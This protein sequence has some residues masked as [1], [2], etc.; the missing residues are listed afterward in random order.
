MSEQIF[1][2]YRR[3]DGDFTAKLICE[4][5]KNRGYT[6]FYDYDSLHDGYFN[7]KIM[8]AIE[9]CNDFVLVLPPNALDRCV[10]DDDWLRL[11]I[12]YALKCGINIIPVIL[13]E[14]SFPDVLPNDIANVKN[15]NGVHFFMPYFDA[16]IATIENR[17]FSSKTSSGTET[18]AT[19]DE[20]KASEGLEFIMHTGGDGYMVSKGTCTDKKPVIPKFYNGKP[21]LYI[22]NRAFAEDESLESIVIPDGI[23][24]IGEEAFQSCES[25][26]SIV[27]PDS[28]YG[29]GNNVFESC[30]SLASVV[31]PKSLVYIPIG[32]FYD[33][34][35]LTSVVIPNKV[36]GIGDFA[37]SS[38]ESLTS[39]SIPNSV[40]TIGDDAFSHC[41]SLTSIS[42]PNSV[43]EIGCDAFSSCSSL[44]SIV[45]PD[46]VK[47]LGYHTFAQCAALV[48]IDLPNGITEI[49]TEAFSGCESLVS[50][51]IPR[52]IESIECF[53]FEQCTSLIDV[54]YYGTA[55]EWNKIE[56]GAFWNPA[57]LSSVHCTDTDCPLVDKLAF[58]LNK[59]GDGYI[60]R[61]GIRSASHIVIPRF[62][63]GKPVTE[64]GEKAFKSCSSLSSVIIPNSVTSIGSY[65]FDDCSALTLLVLPDTVTS[66]GDYAFASCS[67][68]PLITIPNNTVTIGE[69]AFSY[70]SSLIIIVLPDSVTEIGAFAFDD[71]NKL[72]SVIYQGTVKQ[73]N[74]IY[75]D[76]Y[77]FPKHISSVLCADGV[78]KIQTDADDDEYDISDLSEEESDDD[79]DDDDIE[80]YNTSD[81]Q[82]H[83]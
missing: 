28:I 16:V 64:I 56:F 24:A 75:L 55:Q 62:Y 70:C 33:C 6:V 46:C 36:N 50:I 54:N 30:S 31:L 26:T 58:S 60:L 1:I 42:I 4:A 72:S 47:R 73:W 79:I 10:N 44:T 34:S 83:F 21:V 41:E 13:P 29:F 66:I 68:L 61:Q 22:A 71:C 40:T 17:M 82:E 15:I 77:S 53:A 20:P 49:G 67:S 43:T 57:T 9:E 76:D 51:N 59:T 37:F 19:A 78:A 25:L 23:L 7:S 38:C 48:S 14:F 8:T 74:D 11:E 18:A 12:R 69:N 81:P 52:S 45:I 39:I 3:E 65:A 32:T 80:I 35:S 5:L 63:N 2:S 27:L